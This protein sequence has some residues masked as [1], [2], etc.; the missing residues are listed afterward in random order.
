MFPWVTDLLIVGRAQEIINSRDTPE[1]DPF[2]TVTRQ[3]PPALHSSANTFPSLPAANL[4]MESV[5][6]SEGKRQGRA[7]LSWMAF[8]KH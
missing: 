2:L 3:P 5:C 7:Y 1:S 6:S 8:Y 4:G